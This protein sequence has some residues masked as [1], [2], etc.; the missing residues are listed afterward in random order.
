[1][2]DRFLCIILLIP[3]QVVLAH[4]QNENE[5]DQPYNIDTK[6]NVIKLSIK[7]LIMI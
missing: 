6:P 1:M 4:E 5:L 3:L 2:L 7:S